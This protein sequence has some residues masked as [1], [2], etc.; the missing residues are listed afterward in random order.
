MQDA[1]LQA[2]PAAGHLGRRV[3]VRFEHPGVRCVIVTGGLDRV[4]CAGANIFM[5]GSSEH[6]FKVNF[7]KYTN[8]TR[9]GIEDASESS[10]VRFLA[11]LNGTASGGGFGTSVGSSS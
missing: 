8:E 11:A 6:G 1:E 7:C 4:F 9:L 3:H 2:M 10:G 5:L